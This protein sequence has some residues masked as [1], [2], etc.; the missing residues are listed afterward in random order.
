M[1]LFLG[2]KFFLVFHTLL[3]LFN[4]SGWIFKKT[5]K[6]HFLTMAATAFSWFFLGIWYGIGFCFCTEWHWQIRLMMGKPI[7]SYS[8]I[9]FLI[10]EITGINL[11]PDIVDTAVMLVFIV[12]ILLTMIVNFR[13][14]LISRSS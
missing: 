9:H 6:A 13:D 10:L 11:N 3:T 7:Q 14:Y 4:I 1:L 5:R 2:D 8:Y 12:V